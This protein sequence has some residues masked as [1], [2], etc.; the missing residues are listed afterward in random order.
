M[1]RGAA[2]REM[3]TGTPTGKTAASASGRPASKLAGSPLRDAAAS[4]PGS[5]RVPL[6]L[7]VSLSG[8][9][10][11]LQD[12]QLRLTYLSQGGE[13]PGVDIAP[14]LGPRRWE[15]PA[16]NL[17]QQDWDRHRAQVEN[18]EAFKDLEIQCLADDGRVVWLSL[19]AQPVLD[20]AGAFGGYLGVGRDVTA[21][22]R[23]RQL[24]D[25]E[26]SVSRCIAEASNYSEAL[27]A[28]LREMGER[29]RFDCVELWRAEENDFLLRRVAQWVAP[30]NIQPFG[31][32]ARNARIDLKAGASFTA[33]VWRT[34]EPRWISDATAESG[35]LAHL[36]TAETGLRSVVF[37]PV[38]S[39]R[40]IVG[41]L[42]LSSRSMRAPDNMFLESLGSIAGLFATVLEGAL[43][44]PARRETDARF[45]RL[46]RLSSDWHWEMDASCSFTCVEGRS[47]EEG[48]AHALIGTHG[49]E[50]GLQIEGGW[51][52]QRALL[53]ARQPFHDV[54]MW[55]AL[56]GGRKCYVR[57]SGE[58]L[59]A[60]AD[61]TFTGYH[62]VGRDVT[63]QKRT[64]QL[65]H[66]EHEVTR[67]LAAAED[68]AEGL[69]SVVRAL[70]ESE[71]W[72]AGRYFRLDDAT[73][74]LHFVDGWCANQTA[75][76]RFLEHSRSQW[77]GGKAA[78]ADNMASFRP[79]M[80]GWY[81]P[82]MEHVERAFA[83]PVVA[84]GKVLGVL[85][86][87]TQAQEGWDDSLQKTAHSI[88]SQV[89]QFLQRKQ[90]E[91]S[92]RESEAR[93]R[94]LSQ[95]S[96]D[97]F[98]ETDPGHRITSIVHSPNYAAPE[99]SY[100]LVGMAA[101]ELPSATPEEAGWA[102]HRAM[103]E[104]GVP[105][106][107]FELSRRMADGKL[108]YFSIS[109][110]P[111]LAGNGGVLGYRGIGRDVTEAAMTRER[112]ALLAFRD[113]LT[114][115]ANRT[116]LTPALEHAVE[117]ARRRGYKLAGVFI[118]LD[119]FKELND[120]HGHDAGDRCLIELARR[121]RANV[122]ASD[123]VARFG[124]DEFFVL[125]EEVQDEAAAQAVVG[126][127][128][129]E[130]VKPYELPGGARVQLSASMGVSLYPDSSGD[131]EALVKHADLAMYS[132]KQAGKNGYF[133]YSSQSG[134][135]LRF[136]PDRR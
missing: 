123:V 99:I 73:G 87:S 34:G 19:S 32:V 92:L 78:W 31:D 125:L 2:G 68:T 97:F 49:W 103:L 50:R 107:D 43:D 110:E 58:P 80:S 102:A 84:D 122:R 109:G 13:K 33:T 47:G 113:P 132:A 44:E 27:S 96:S 24:L 128:L 55:G 88:G 127:L 79:E 15:Q 116:S 82:G 54:L 98:W 48:L 112:I 39:G 8:D 6:P 72:G 100:G 108:R 36:R 89:G 90:A 135:L 106:R 71:G 17:T 136:Q 5:D 129:A 29:E 77:E 28:V 63:L 62:G 18:R 26:H 23:A 37:H 4:R 81:T 9:W 1:K 111:K 11:W 131:A 25:L 56:E 117:R 53:E 134:Q 118:D 83:L 65:Q 130:V 74:A 40:R 57:M 52:D 126:K 67:S 70:C 91:T 115:L 7:L 119:G 41:M 69:R 61:G 3:A 12:A 124:G 35:A 93:Y 14:Y 45:R 30:G 95:M 105:F 94:S 20:H 114:G 86:F 60:A 101:W 10:F 66:M 64:E 46:A 59:F 21:Q 22:R 104:A 16:L 42:Q 133:M 38:R 76:E 85:A 51:E 120:A 121:L 75:V